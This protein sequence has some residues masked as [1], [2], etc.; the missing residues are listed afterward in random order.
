MKITFPHMG[1]IY[2]PGRLFCKNWVTKSLCPVGHAAHPRA[3]M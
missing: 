3:G 1:S 2:I